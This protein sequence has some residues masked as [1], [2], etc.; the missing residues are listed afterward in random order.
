MTDLRRFLREDLGRRGDVTS[1]VLF[2]RR[3]PEAH[4]VIYARHEVVVAGAE[5]ASSVFRRL[6][7]LPTIRLRDGNH[8]R[9]GRPILAVRGPVS[10]ILT[11]ERLA[12]NF[13]GRMSGIA[14]LTRRY[15]ELVHKVNPAC[16]VAA[17]RKTTPG[18]RIHEKKAVVLGG[19]APHR[20]GLYDGILIKDNHLAAYP[21]VSA[22]VLRA[23]RARTR[24][25]I[26]VEVST[27]KDAREAAM[28]GA[29]WILLDNLSPL[30]ARRAA[31]AARS[32][33]TAVRIEV[34]GG[35]D[36]RNVSR[37]APFADRVSLGR[38]T[39]SAPSADVTLD[40]RVPKH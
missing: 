6:G 38:L 37:Y 32:V 28:A 36:E 14:T 8:A 26:E 27:E 23:R 1:R 39:H 7:C 25:P 15:V 12:L 34:S 16:E 13:L 33:R 20:M 17:T 22:A 2:G 30:A 19:G 40:L 10:R 5:E 24:L 29:D 3:G 35:L 4:A 11:G 31:E 9:T 18:F 21:G